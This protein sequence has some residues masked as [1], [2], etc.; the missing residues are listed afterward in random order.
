MLKRIALAAVCVLFGGQGFAGTATPY[1]EVY[2]A[3]VMR[4]ADKNKSGRLEKDENPNEWKKYQALDVNRDEVLTLDELREAKIHY[5]E[6]G[7]ERKLNVLYKQTPEEDLYLDIYYPTAKRGEQCPVVFYTHGGG[8][9]AGD[10]QSAA[11]HLY[12]PVFKKLLDQGFC[13]VA[14]NYRLWKSGGAPHVP[15]CVADSKDAMRYMAKNSKALQV[16]PN[17]F[18]VIGGSAGGHLAQMLLL[19]PPEAQPGDPALVD[20]PY[21]MVA[22]VSWFGFTNVEVEDLFIKNEENPRP[23]PMHGTT[24]R[25]LKPGLTESEKAAVLH[26]MS[27]TTW[28]SKDSPP[29]LIM[30][31]DRDTAVTVKHAHYIQQRAEKLGAATE[32]VIVKKAGHNWGQ[33]GV[34]IEPSMDEIID[35]TVQFF[36]EHLSAPASDGWVIDTLAEWEQSVESK[37]GIEVVDGM[38]SPTEKNATFRSVLKRF[39]TKREAES[40]TV[41][42]SDAWKNWNPCPNIGPKLGDSP[43]FISVGPQ[44]YWM[45]GRCHMRPKK[46]LE[47]VRLPGYDE[48]LLKTAKPNEFVAPG[49]LEPHAGGYQAWHS[50]DM[51][52]WVYY[53]SV[54]EKFSAWVTSA[55]YADGKFYIYYDFPNDQDP[56]L[57]IDD[58]L[59]DGKPGKNMGMAFNDPTHGSDSGFIRDLDGNFHVIYE[60]WS[61]IH[62]NSHSFDS[63]LAGHAVSKDGK[64]DF[65]VLAPA[66]D[67]R[68]TPTGVLK[69]Y[70][71][72]HWVKEC[73]ER[74]TSD[75]G[76]YEVHE[77]EQDCFGDW[78]AL[79]IGG[80][81]YLFGDYDPAG[82]HGTK[83]SN[84][85]VAW[86]TSS[87]LSEPFELCGHVGQGH[88]DPDICFAEGRFWLATQPEI[89]FVSPGPWVESVEVRVGIDLSNDG[90]IDQWTQWFEVKESY[91]HTPGFAKH[92]QR[93][94]AQL[95]LSELPAAYGFQYELKLTDTT[96]NQ[97]KPVID[98]VSM[99]F[100]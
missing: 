6:T 24:V 36:V 30:H 57:Y 77:P 75:I 89:D 65:E 43:V 27:P 88:P 93:T 42:Q 28:L 41:K 63:P 71:H 74:F 99:T 37:T 2:A 98:E 19:T 66:V 11:N 96:K 40:L 3:R 20:T 18:F 12:G 92:V 44:D 21:T 16:D 39:D 64:G 70:R 67:L 35:K 97:S 82:S 85:S 38:I 22:G 7:G 26:E 17:C 14:L 25:I 100:Y 49:G 10:K 78:S 55:E 23:K 59:T 13:V 81:Y 95:D 51:K 31:G 50:R 56:H 83:G 4:F 76:E 91:D 80:Q 53:G 69:T 1:E 86:F 5:L 8:W 84:M 32:V 34:V 94:P 60:D 73:P 47:E 58:D 9:G 54:T 72:P 61:P 79:C 62:A 52:N 48:P 15:E 45:L 68:T 29:M 33:R 87:S 90:K 46:P